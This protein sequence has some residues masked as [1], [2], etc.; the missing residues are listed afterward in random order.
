MTVINVQFSTDKKLI[1]NSD[2]FIFIANS[3]AGLIADFTDETVEGKSLF[4]NLEL[5]DISILKRIVRLDI[6]NEKQD[7]PSSCEN[8]IVREDGTSIRIILSVL[9]HACARGNTPSRAHA[10]STIMKKYPQIAGIDLS[11]ILHLP[12][13]IYYLYN[14]LFSNTNIYI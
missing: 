7:D 13:S 2:T 5:H 12:I 10:V 14:Y 4:A 3:K 11:I 9:P 6:L 1:T 8:F